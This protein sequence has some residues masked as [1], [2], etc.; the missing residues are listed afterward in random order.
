M[1]EASSSGQIRAPTTVTSARTTSTERV[2]TDGPTA[3]ST[4]GNGSITRWRAMALSLGAMAVATSAATKMT[5]STAREHLNGLTVVSI[6]ENGA[7]ANNMEKASTSK[8][9]KRDRASGKWAKELNGSKPQHRPLKRISPE[10]LSDTSYPNI[11]LTHYIDL[12]V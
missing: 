6:S 4:T 1:V 8:K 3:E 2:S 9:A 12:A 11:F 10:T 7:K 5:R